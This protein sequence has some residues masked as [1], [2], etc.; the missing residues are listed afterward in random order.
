MVR[1]LLSVIWCLVCCLALAWGQG[2]GLNGYEGNEWI[3]TKYNTTEGKEF[4]VTFMRNSGGDE[5]DVSA[6]KLYLYATSRENAHVTIENPNTGYTASFDVTAP[7]QSIFLVPNSEAYVQLPGIESNL[8]L[9]VT[10]DKPISLY[11]TSHH[12]SGKYDATNVLPTT[13]LLGEY[14]VQTY[15]NDQYATE[16]AVV[17]TKSQTITIDIRETVINKDSFDYE[18]KIIIDSVIEKQI[19]V[20]LTAGQCYLYRSSNISGSLSGTKICSEEPFALFNGGQSGKI[21]QEPENHLFHQAYPTDKLGRNFYVVPTHNAIMDVVRFTAISPGTIIRRN[22]TYLTTLVHTGDTYQDTIWSTATIHPGSP[23]YITQNPNATYYATSKE[24][25]CYLYGTGYTDNL[26]VNNPDNVSKI[27]NYI[28]G[29]PV[30]TPIIPQEYACHSNIFATFN[31]GSNHVTNYV[32]IVTYTA[33]KGGMRL[34][35]QDIS[36]EFNPIREQTI[37]M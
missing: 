25:E 29:S 18:E 31:D 3:N 26:G 35:D 33:E 20:S 10:S 8:G 16:F 14:V 37:H 22:G 28:M 2:V 11:A 5:T 17:A 7:H 30:M 15:L 19:S 1:R 32:N 6:M 24:A 21:T 23:P 13:A 12:R 34:D 4:W 27:Q 36:G 9:R